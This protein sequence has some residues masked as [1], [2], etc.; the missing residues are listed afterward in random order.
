MGKEEKHVVT[1]TVTRQRARTGTAS[2]HLAVVIHTE[3][4]ER[5]ILQRIGGNPF[6]DAQTENL[7]GRRVRVSG[8]RLGDIL[9]Y[10]TA[11]EA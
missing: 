3:D 5:L 7:V 2:E 10:A 6:Q 9:R 4:G 11:E 1:G 8:F